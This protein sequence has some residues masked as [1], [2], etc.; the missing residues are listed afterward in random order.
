M[1]LARSILLAAICLGGTTFAAH[2]QWQYPPPYPYSQ[3]PATPPAWS[4][5]PYTSGFGPCPQ[6]TPND[7]LSCRDQMPPT[8]GQP[9]YRTRR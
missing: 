7:S 5:D 6:R 1:T 4:Y 3:V 2:A 8:F 9:D